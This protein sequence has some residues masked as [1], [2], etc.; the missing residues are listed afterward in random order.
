MEFRKWLIGVRQDF[1]V[2]PLCNGKPARAPHI[3]DFC[4]PLCWRCTSVVGSTIICAAIHLAVQ[5]DYFQW[6]GNVIG[7]AAILFI[8]PMLWDGWIQYGRHR[9]S[10]N[11][12]RLVTGS[13]CGIG[14]WFWANLLL[15]VL[16]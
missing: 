8:S 1:G 2:T 16:D 7:M 11:V 9:E 12:R 6:G 5:I 15:S 10:T 3:G 4:F 14:V 13:L